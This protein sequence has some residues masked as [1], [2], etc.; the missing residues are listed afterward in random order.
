MQGAKE[1]IRGAVLVS[2]AFLLI[3]TSYNAIENLETS[4]IRGECQGCLSGSPTGIC[5][6]GHVCQDKVQFACDEACAAPFHECSSSLG[7]T[8]LGVIYLTFT[9]SAFMGPLIPNHF[10]MKKSMFGSAFVYALFAFANLVVVLNPTNQTLHWIVML[11]AAFLEGVAASVL[12]IAQATYLTQLSVLYAEFKHEPVV[13]SMGLF[14]GVFYSIFRM[15]AISGNLISSLVLGYFVWPAES[16]FVMYTVIGLSGA[17]LMLML[18]STTKVS[19]TNDTELAKLVQTP[20][21][22]QGNEPSRRG[23]TF[24][25]LWTMATD[26]RMVVLAPVFVLNGL[27]QGFATG[28]FTSNFIR[29]SVGGAS[30]GYVMALYGGCNVVSSYGFGKLADKYGPLGG[31]LVGFGAMLV[32]FSL[33]YWIP[34]EKCDQQWPLVV[35]IAVLLSLGDASST[36]LTSGATSSFDAILASPIHDVENS[37]VC[38][39]CLL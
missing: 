16:L 2:V 28:E 29:E 22:A 11:P 31:Q 26:N 37:L 15:S 14:N 33:C 25:G 32:A 39:Y 21:V 24:Q 18:P 36:T 6:S 9:L 10:G 4:I 30:I 19:V 17:A 20:S 5:Q 7:S 35:V 38:G 3:F 13:S 23:F 8:I 12:W 1:C 27:Q 34:V